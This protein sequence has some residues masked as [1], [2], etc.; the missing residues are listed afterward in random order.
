[1]GRQPMH[2]LVLQLD[3]QKLTGA[4]DDVVGPFVMQGSIV[5]G[6]VVIT[7]QYL[8]AHAVQYTGQWDGEGTYNGVWSIF[9]VG[10]RW[11]IRIVGTDQTGEITSL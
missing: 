2:N 1:M 10:G 5:E 9:G 7:K 6:Q 8:Q 3:G 11:A 4:G